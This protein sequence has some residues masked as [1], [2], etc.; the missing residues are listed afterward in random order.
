MRTTIV[1]LCVAMLALAAGCAGNSA[2]PNAPVALIKEN[3]ASC[4]PL[5]RVKSASH[6]LA[7]WNSTIT[8]MRTKGV[9]LTDQQAADIAAFLA[10]G[11]GSQL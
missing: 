2:Q 4:H 3:C 5:D 7:G 9:Q 11:G 10:G 6:D 8:R 1:L